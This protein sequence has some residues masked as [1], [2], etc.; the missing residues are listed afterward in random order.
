MKL[1][2]NNNSAFGS[3]PL[4]KNQGVQT[5][6]KLNILDRIEGNIKRKSDTLEISE[7]GKLKLKLRNL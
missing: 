1:N 2:F 3:S 7:Q 5:S 6:N 4:Y